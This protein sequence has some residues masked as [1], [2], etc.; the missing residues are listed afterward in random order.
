MAKTATADNVVELNP[1]PDTTKVVTL[2]NARIKRQEPMK[3]AK[4][5]YDELCKQQ[6]EKYN[7]HKKAMN[8]GTKML[9]MSDEKW[10]DYL[11][12]FEPMFEAIKDHRATVGTQDMMDQ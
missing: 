3:E 1:S 2:L 4:T 12:T 6:N 10:Q 7:L 11:R 9:K 8:D 5:D